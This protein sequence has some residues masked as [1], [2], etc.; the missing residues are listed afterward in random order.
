MYQYFAMHEIIDPARRGSNINF[1][2]HFSGTYLE[3]FLWQ[4]WVNSMP[5]HVTDGRSTSVQVMVLHHQASPEKMSYQVLTQWP[6]KD[7][8]LI[9]KVSSSNLLQCI[10]NSSPC[11]E[12]ALRWMPH[13]LT[14]EKSTLVQVMAWWRCW[15]RSMLPYGVTKPQCVEKNPRS[16]LIRV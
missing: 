15:P 2:T 4:F 8:T 3:Y 1:Q 7:E 16:C 13:N 6:L 5:Q 9:L 14:N 12:I 10:Q 11:C